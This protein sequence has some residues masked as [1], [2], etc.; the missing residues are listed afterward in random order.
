[1]LR[2]DHRRRCPTARRE[3]DSFQAK[4]RPPTGTA[5]RPAKS[6]EHQRGSSA[7]GSFVPKLRRHTTS[8]TVAVAEIYM[9]LGRTR[10]RR[11]AYRV[12]S[13]RCG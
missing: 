3:A 12:F 5:T 10:S 8:E 11:N 1:M 9:D 2:L 7:A 6:P 4:N 13:G